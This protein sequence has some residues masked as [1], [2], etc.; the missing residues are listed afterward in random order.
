MMSQHIKVRKLVSCLF[1]SHKNVICLC[2]E[3]EVEGF[4]GKT[5]LD[6]ID[7]IAIYVVFMCKTLHENLLLSITL[8]T[9][10]LRI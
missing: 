5:T 7:F 1:V 8:G 6:A 2:Y 4:L 9:L 3:P 10:Q